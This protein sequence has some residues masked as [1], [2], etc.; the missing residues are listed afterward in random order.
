MSDDLI[1]RHAAI[2]WVKTECNPYGKPALDFESSKKV[3][4]HL[5]QMP[6]ADKPKGEWIY[7][8]DYAECSN[9]G[10][11]SGTQFDGVEPVPRETK[12]CPDCGARMKRSRR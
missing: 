12:F 2:R 7:K 8:G 4:E 1:S 11:D 5:E 3:I 9:C 6:S 10:A